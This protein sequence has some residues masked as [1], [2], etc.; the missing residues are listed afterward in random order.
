M[1][2]LTLC[3]LLIFAA[4]A[5]GLWA[6]Q[7]QAIIYGKDNGADR[8]LTTA[9]LE[10]PGAIS[11][12]APQYQGAVSPLT[13]KAWKMRPE[14][15]T[16]QQYEAILPARSQYGLQFDD[17]TDQIGLYSSLGSFSDNLCGALERSPQWLRAEL[18][19]TLLQLTEAKRELYSSLI[20]TTADPLIDEVAFSIAHSSPQ[21]LN[22]ELE[23]RSSSQRMP[24]IS[25]V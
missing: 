20:L 17:L 7:S 24:P 2:Q 22:S 9:E 1:K 14:T 10:T 18:Q 19:N 15:R 25:T 8:G 4:L 23:G 3:M 6:G 13:N 16:E 11:V 12:S 21:Y 5:P